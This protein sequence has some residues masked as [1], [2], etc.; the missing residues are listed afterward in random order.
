MTVCLVSGGVG[1]EGVMGM[2][3]ELLGEMIISFLTWTGFKD[4]QSNAIP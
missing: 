3:M 1:R 2:S 4:R